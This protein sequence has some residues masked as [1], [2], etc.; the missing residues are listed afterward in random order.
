CIERGG[1]LLKSRLLDAASFFPT[2]NQNP[3]A[4]FYKYPYPWQKG[5]SGSFLN[6]AKTSSRFALKNEDCDKAYVK[7]CEALGPYVS[8]NTHSISWI[9]LK[10]PLGAYPESVE[11]DFVAKDNLKVSSFYQAPYSLWHEV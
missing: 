4:Y 3:N 1:K 2:S 8:D 11:N 5:K 6:E 10:A 9:G 7:G